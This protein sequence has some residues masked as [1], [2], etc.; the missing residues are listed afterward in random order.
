M[1]FAPV[2]ANS[3]QTGAREDVWNGI[4]DF[5]FSFV[6]L[7]VCVSECVCAPVKCLISKNL[8]ML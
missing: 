3:F 1:I 5:Y 6:C 2:I 7:R 8:H 4:R